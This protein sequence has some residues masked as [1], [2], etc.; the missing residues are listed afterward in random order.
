MDPNWFHRKASRDKPFHTDYGGV[1]CDY[2]PCKV[3]ELIVWLAFTLAGTLLPIHF[4][5]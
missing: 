2:L 5:T 3:L 1:L 4:L